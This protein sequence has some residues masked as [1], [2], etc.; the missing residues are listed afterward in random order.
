[1]ITKIKNLAIATLALALAACSGNER[2]G[3]VRSQLLD[4]VPDKTPVVISMNPQKLLQ[5]AGGDWT[6]EDGIVPGQYI[7]DFVAQ[8]GNNDKDV[9][10]KID[11]FLKIQGLNPESLIIASD[12]NFRQ[13]YVLGALCDKSGLED[14]VTK[15]Y[16]EKFSTKGDFDVASLGGASLLVDNADALVWFTTDSDADDAVKAVKNIK[17]RAADKAMPDWTRDYLGSGDNSF[18][19]LGNFGAMGVNLSGLLRMMHVPADLL[20]GDI[21]YLAMYYK[22]SGSKVTSELLTLGEDGK[23]VPLFNE[24]IYQS[25]DLSAYNLLPD[26]SNMKM[27]LGISGAEVMEYI[28]ELRK[29]TGD[30]MVSDLIAS[31]QSIAFGAQSYDFSAMNSAISGNMTTYPIKGMALLVK[32][33]PGKCADLMKILAT[34]PQMETI[35]EANLKFNLPQDELAGLS[36]IYFSNQNDALL[37]S[38]EN[39]KT[40]RGSQTLP[41]GALAYSYS[42][43]NIYPKDGKLGFLSEMF[44][45]STGSWDAAGFHSEAELSDKC[46]GMLAVMLKAIGSYA[47]E[48]KNAANAELAAGEFNSADSIDFEEIEVAEDIE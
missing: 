2:K 11:E 13:W 9:K 39:L 36:T 41:S 44:K 38:T 28:P 5:S 43:G 22:E 12:N 10:D 35:D 1:M 47:S 7:E 31:V 18:G 25:S 4:F 48:I 33:A 23:S 26:G 42:N 3:D 17:S 6:E 32:F 24:K 27:A 29:L 34:V 46:P 20:G 15:N 21:E 8:L 40:G 37:I 19:V 14:Y 45:S 30:P 16:D